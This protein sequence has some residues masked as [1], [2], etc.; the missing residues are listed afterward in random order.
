[1]KK[2]NKDPKGDLRLFG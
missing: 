1:M 2:R